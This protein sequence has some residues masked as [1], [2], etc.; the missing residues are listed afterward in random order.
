M[1]QSRWVLIAVTG[2]H[3]C[4]S[5][6]DRSNIVPEATKMSSDT[7][8]SG[9][10]TADEL[11]QWLIMISVALSVVPREQDFNLTANVTLQQLQTIKCVFF[12]TLPLLDGGYYQAK[13]LKWGISASLLFSII[14]WCRDM[15]GNKAS[16]SLLTL[17]VTVF[18]FTCWIRHVRR[19][20]G[21]LFRDLIIW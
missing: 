18:D 10:G 21:Q 20:E 13:L 1:V 16:V 8:A 3:S 11:L 12:F 7:H 6:F 14:L 19:C 4:F 15:S 17:L 5:R 9:H 2:C